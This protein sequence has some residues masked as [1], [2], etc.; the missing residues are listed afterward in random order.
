MSFG[1]IT[2]RPLGRPSVVSSSRKIC[3]V[4]PKLP[5]T[6]TLLNT[7]GNVL[8]AVAVTQFAGGT[9]GR[10]LRGSGHDVR[11]A[12]ER[13]ADEQVARLDLVAVE[14]GGVRGGAGAGG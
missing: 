13:A 9:P 11:G 12:V 4:I 2:I 5:S 6:L 7:C 14:T 10:K 3:D 1:L 8:P